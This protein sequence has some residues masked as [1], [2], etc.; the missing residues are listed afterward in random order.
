M[1]IA[2]SIADVNSRKKSRYAIEGAIITKV[3]F[4][5]IMKETKK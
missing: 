3:L 2:M 4:A 1:L 5:L